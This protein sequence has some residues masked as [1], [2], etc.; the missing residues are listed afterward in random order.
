MEKIKLIIEEKELE[1]LKDLVKNSNYF[2]DNVLKQSVKELVEEFKDSQVLTQE[3]MPGDAVR[4]N[5]KV[6]VHLGNGWTNEFK[7]VHPKDSNIK[8]NLFS[9]LSPMGFALYG[10]REGDVFTWNFP[11]GPQTIT[12]TKVEN[13]EVE[14]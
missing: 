3:E 4:L 6:T 9:I 11:A 12:V 2:N 1:V 7:I 14:S 13:S 5:S 8:Q 10:H